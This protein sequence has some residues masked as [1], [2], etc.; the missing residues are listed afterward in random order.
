MWHIKHFLNER[1]TTFGELLVESSSFFRVIDIPETVWDEE[2]KNEG[3]NKNQTWPAGSE[4]VYEDTC[5]QNRWLFND[6]AW[7]KGFWST[8]FVHG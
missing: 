7:H 8:C 5:N 1:V 4:K 2:G 6:R 3:K